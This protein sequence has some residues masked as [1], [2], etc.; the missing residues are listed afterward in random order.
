ME[1]IN[2]NQKLKSVP[3]EFLQNANFVLDHLNSCLKDYSLMKQKKVTVI[4]TSLY[5]D[6][7]KN[8]SVKGVATSQHLTAQ[9]VDFVIRSGSSHTELFLWL[10]RH[11]IFDQLAIEYHDNNIVNLHM[12]ILKANNRKMAF[13][14]FY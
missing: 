6:S 14:K 13:Q 8:S 5:R 3:P 10:K 2:L 11:C 1:Y 9:A 4:I 12:S 7:K